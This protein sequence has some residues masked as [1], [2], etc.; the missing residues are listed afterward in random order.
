V[1]H[2]CVLVGHSP[3]RDSRAQRTIR[4][5]TKVADVD[6]CFPH[7]PG[8]PVDP[9]IFPHNVRL[10]PCALTPS[11]IDWL[12]RHSFFFLDS[13]GLA[14]AVISSGER[15]DL[16]YAH[17]ILTTHAAVR[18]A[19]AQGATLAYDVHDLSIETAN[20]LF[21]LSSRGPKHILYRGD[22]WLLRTVGR[23]WEARVARACD[24]IFTTNPSY[25]GYLRANYGNPRVYVAPNYPERRI[26]V[27][28][29]VLQQRLGVSENVNLVL[30]HGVLGPGRSLELIVRSARWY[31]E[32]TQ[33][34]ILG[35]GPLESRLRAI[36]Q[37]DGL[38]A[39]V[40]F[41]DLVHYEDLFGYLSG[42]HLGLVLI[43]PINLSKK[44]ALA[45]KVTEYMA[46][47]VPLLA[48]SSPENVRLVTAGQCGF[49]RDFEAPE[50]LGR[51]VNETMQDR[52]RLSHLGANGQ[53]AFLDQ[54]NWEAHEPGFLAPICA[55][56]HLE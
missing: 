4:S 37:R 53:R 1:K 12:L 14:R 52:A 54:F 56:L 31:S 17:D 33:L 48:S 55:L 19:R 27:R 13:G 43:E 51:F 18:I 35:N 38:E 2:V 9:A 3:N 16:V 25:Q 39:A 49:V 44:Y 41:V 21:P 50:D 34:V 30:Y 47:G 29:T 28:S 6:L 7:F 23:W 11:R 40:R 32:G 15:Y 5:I 10:V 36:V 24:A 20:Q 8:D 26:V 42:A 22:L 46:A 45:N